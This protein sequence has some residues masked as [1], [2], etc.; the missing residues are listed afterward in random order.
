MAA[1]ST[2]VGPTPERRVETDLPPLSIT[3]LD[4]PLSLESRVSSDVF[5]KACSGD[6]RAWSRRSRSGAWNFGSSY[7][8]ADRFPDTHDQCS[9]RVSRPR[10]PCDRQVSEGR[11][12][13]PGLE[14]FGPSGVA[15]GRPR[16]RRG[17]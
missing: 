5:D 6:S 3:I 2:T 16:H 15:V 8:A 11:G 7:G 12:S 17:R 10:R 4:Q 14:T 13:A 9:A 1:D